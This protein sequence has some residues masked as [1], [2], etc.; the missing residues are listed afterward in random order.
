[1]EGVFQSCPLAAFLHDPGSETDT[2]THRKKEGGRETRGELKVNKAEGFKGC[3][4]EK[5]QDSIEKQIKRD[6]NDENGAAEEMVRLAELRG[7]KEG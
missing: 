4:K 3:N 1:M 6:A 5:R 2:L 7:K